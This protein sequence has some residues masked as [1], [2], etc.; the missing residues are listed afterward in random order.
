MAQATRQSSLE[1]EL[2]EDVEIKASAKKYYQML[3]GR[4]N[5]IAKSTPDNVK[6]CTLRQGEF[7]KLGSVI[8]W[9]YV[10]DGEPKVMKQRI[11]AV[12]HEKNLLVFKV[13][14][15]DMMK[16]FKS[17][18]ISIHATPKLRGPGS[19]V[20][21]HFKYERIDEKVAHPEKL[22]A[23]IIKASRDMGEMLLSEV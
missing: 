17:F 15:G 13:I 11:M 1:G 7:G 12:D 23:L 3:A 10:I 5:D 19:V 9:N 20:S 2:K 22:L 21:C 6:G 16:D 18:F 14:D 8:V 4:P